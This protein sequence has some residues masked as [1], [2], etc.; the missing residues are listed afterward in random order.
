MMAYKVYNWYMNI[1][2]N[3]PDGRKYCDHA[4]LEAELFEEAQKKAE[5]YC[6]LMNKMYPGTIHTPTGTGYKIER[7]RGFH[8]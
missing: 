6:E 3:E 4:I 7:T 5:V 1:R 2:V 8:W